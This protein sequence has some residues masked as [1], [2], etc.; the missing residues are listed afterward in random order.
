MD[1]T[2]DQTWKII[3]GLC[4][5]LDTSSPASGDI[6]RLLRT[7]K[8]YEE[9]GEVDEALDNVTGTGTGGF[10]WQD[11][12]TELCDVI[13]TGMVAIASLTPDP[14]AALHARTGR[15]TTSP[16]RPWDAVR[17]LTHPDGPSVAARTRQMG[18]AAGRV[19]AAVHGAMAG[20][21]RKGSS[22]TWAD[23][24]DRIA[25]VVLHAMSLLTLLTPDAE[26][27]FNE[28]LARIAQRSGVPA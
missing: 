1:Q 2:M 23:V 16:T 28:R 14:A 22:H 15:L 5:W 27:I 25:D 17:A 21:P 3:N 13:V 7:I 24:A 12:N 4:G 10:T 20:N 9:I 11:V 19:A 8:L 26:K 6:A 18:T